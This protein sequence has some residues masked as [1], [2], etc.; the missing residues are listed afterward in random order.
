MWF[1]ETPFEMSLGK[2]WLYSAFCLLIALFRSKHGFM[3]LIRLPYSGEMQE[4]S[5]S[6]PG[7]YF[8]R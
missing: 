8:L 4:K 3:L 7:K 2:R 1:L 6:E 5:S